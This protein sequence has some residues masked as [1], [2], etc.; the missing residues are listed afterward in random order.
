M[1]AS[2]TPRSLRTL[3]HSRLKLSGSRHVPAVDVKIIFCSPTYGNFRR[4]V[5]V[6]IATVC[7]GMVRLPAPVL[8]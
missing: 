5:S 3:R 8:V 1:V 6:S 7:S 4:A 2:G